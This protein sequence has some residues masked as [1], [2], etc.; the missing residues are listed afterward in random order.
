MSAHSML[1]TH[2]WISWPCGSTSSSSTCMSAPAADM[3]ALAALEYYS[4]HHRHHHKRR[5]HWHVNRAA[6]TGRQGLIASM[7]ACCCL[8]GSRSC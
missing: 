5:Q 3:T 1:C 8:P 4:P 2:L 6:R 7:G